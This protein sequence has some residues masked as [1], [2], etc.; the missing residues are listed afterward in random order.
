MKFLPLI[1]FGA[2]VTAGGAMAAMSASLAMFTPSS[3]HWV[4][5]TG[6]GKG[7]WNAVMVGDPAKSGNAIMRVKEPDGY[8]NTPHY[9]AHDE[10]ITVIQGALLFGTGDTVDKSKAKLLPTGSFV[11]VPAGVHHWSVTQGVTIEQVGGQGPLNNI[12]IKKGAM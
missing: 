10:Y 2:V 7:T 11:M 12:P 9:H 6:P 3:L 5:Q 8:V 4:A 1:L